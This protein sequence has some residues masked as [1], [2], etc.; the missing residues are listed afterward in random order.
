MTHSFI[1]AT[2]GTSLS[3]IPTEPWLGSV[4]GSDPN[5]TVEMMAHVTLTS[6]CES[7]LAATAALPITLFPIQNQEN[8]VW[9]QCFEAVSV[10]EGPH[11]SVDMIVMAKYVQYLFNLQHNTASTD[12]QQLMHL[13]TCEEHAFEMQGA[14]LEERVETIAN[15][16]QQLLEL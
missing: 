14:E 13:T 4:I 11:F 8:P 9:Q 3:F 6:L 16:K 12:M 10:L 7:R 15:L 1:S 2:I 5:T